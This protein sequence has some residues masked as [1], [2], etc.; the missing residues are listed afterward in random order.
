MYSISAPAE[1]A[2]SPSPVIIITFTLSSFSNCL[3]VVIISFAT[4][5]TVMFFS[6]F[7]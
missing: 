2:L 1:N 6:Y 7:F 4:S 3:K 5:I